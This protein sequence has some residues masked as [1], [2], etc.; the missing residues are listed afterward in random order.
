MY[1]HKKSTTSYLIILLHFCFLTLQ[2]NQACK[3]NDSTCPTNSFCNKNN[4]CQCNEGYALDC[5]IVSTKLT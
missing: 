1:Y 5:S 4:Y 2:I 3:Q